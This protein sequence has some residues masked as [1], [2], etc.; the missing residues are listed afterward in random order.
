MQESGKVEIW[1][2]ARQAEL[3]PT[4]CCQY[5]LAFVCLGSPRFTSVL[6]GFTSVQLWLAVRPSSHQFAVCLLARG[7]I[8]QAKAECVRQF[9]P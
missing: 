4:G 3:E 2:L 6:I 9:N 7:T 8:C 1:L 5:V